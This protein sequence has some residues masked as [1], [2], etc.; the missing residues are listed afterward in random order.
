VEKFVDFD[1]KPDT[2]AKTWNLVQARV[3]GIIEGIKNL[4]NTNGKADSFSESN[5]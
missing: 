4:M 2:R 1:P 5:E 3:K